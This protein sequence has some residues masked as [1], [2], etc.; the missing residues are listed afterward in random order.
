VPHE[1]AKLRVERRWRTLEEADEDMDAVGHM[2]GL[3]GL[4][5]I[6]NLA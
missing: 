6:V 4:G 1:F 2:R 5:L 3:E